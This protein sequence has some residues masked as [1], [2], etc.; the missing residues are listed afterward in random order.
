MGDLATTGKGLGHS[1]L[2]FLLFSCSGQNTLDSINFF[3]AKLFLTLTNSIEL[4]Y[5]S[6]DFSGL[7]KSISSERPSRHL[8]LDY[9]NWSGANFKT[10]RLCLFFFVEGDANRRGQK[11]ER[12]MYGHLKLVEIPITQSC[13][14]EQRPA[15]DNRKGAGDREWVL[16]HI[17]Y[18]TMVMDEITDDLDDELS[19]RSLQVVFEGY[20]KN[21]KDVRGHK[22]R[23]TY[24]L[25]NIARDDISSKILETP[26][27]L[28]QY[29][30]SRELNYQI[31]LRVVNLR[32]EHSLSKIEAA[33]TIDTEIKEGQVCHR[34]N[35][36]CEEIQKYQC[37]ECGGGMV[38][39]KGKWVSGRR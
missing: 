34:I 28:Q 16:P 15:S 38:R 26:H 10:S 5:I 20:I 32:Q 12:R 2:L 29:A 7:Q 23:W 33:K 24:P 8:L 1:M 27:L 35:E 14:R 11:K 25:Y 36:N 3:Q 22:I 19:Q 18:L 6:K 9:Q 39:G 17:R 31:G 30:S 13:S 21:P 4:F 37:D